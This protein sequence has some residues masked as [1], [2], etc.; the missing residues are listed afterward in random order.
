MPTQDAEALLTANIELVT[1]TGYYPYTQGIL[2]P[3]S[4]TIKAT[5]TGTWRSLSG[6]TWNTTVN[7]I[8]NLNS[9]IWTAPTLDLGSIDWFCL[10]ITA[11]FDGVCEY[12]IHVSS[13]GEFQGEESETLV[14]EGATN[15]SAFYGRYVSVTAR[16][17]GAELRRLT[18]ESSTDKTLIRLPDVDTTTLGGTTST[19]T[20]TL[21]QPIS[22]VYDINIEPKAATSYAVDLYV[23]S[24]ATSEVLIPV[25]KSKSSTPSFVLYGIDNIARDGIVDITITALPRMIMAAGNLIV[26]R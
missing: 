5:G 10:D 9:I 7:Y 3:I 1:Q 15:V 25:V 6:T 8:Q 21:S 17:S 24:T 11:E 20:I 14:Q 12:L 23:S 13:T 18:V 2:D 16:V 26:V 19:R 22:R 4:G